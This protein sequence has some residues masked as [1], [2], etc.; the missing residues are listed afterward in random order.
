MDAPVPPPGAPPPDDVATSQKM[1][2]GLR[3]EVARLRAEG[4]ALKSKLGQALKHRFG[5]RSERRPKP[6]PAADDDK[7]AEYDL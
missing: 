7:P 6:K 4:A 5:R 1:V 2:R 3:A